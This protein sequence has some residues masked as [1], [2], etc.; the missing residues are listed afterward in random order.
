MNTYDMQ[1]YYETK[2]YLE[3]Y[4]G[5]EWTIE[6]KGCYDGED[7]WDLRFEIKNFIVEIDPVWIEAKF[8]LTTEQFIQIGREALIEQA[9]AEYDSRFG[10]YED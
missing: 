2:I 8:P 4:D 6:V 9:N 1:H 3:C 10:D 5:L 7:V